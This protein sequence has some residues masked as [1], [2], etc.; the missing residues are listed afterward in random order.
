MGMIRCARCGASEDER[1][2]SM[3]EDGMVCQRCFQ[4]EVARD[5]AQRQAAVD[6]ARYAANPDGVLIDG[7][8]GAV[9]LATALASGSSGG[10]NVVSNDVLQQGVH[11]ELLRR[12]CTCQRASVSESTTVLGITKA[13]EGYAETWLLPHASAVQGSFASEGLWQRLGKI[14]SR[15]LQTGDA[16][17]DDAVFIK[18]STPEAVQQWLQPPVRALVAAV[19][20]NNGALTIDG[21][22]VE[23]KVLWDP[24]SATIVEQD[25]FAKIVATLL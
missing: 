25:L 18:T 19:I 12:G 6:A 1:S 22:M 16:A 8:M 3:S 20:A 23:G 2:A 9:R 5:D 14:F 21:N 11:A 15:E 10:V 13:L 17:F 4:G 7:T 24:S